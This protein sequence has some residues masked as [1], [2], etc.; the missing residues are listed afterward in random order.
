MMPS[1]YS[2]WKNLNALLVA[3]VGR[4]K[5]GLLSLLVEGQ[6]VLFQT[7]RDAPGIGIADPVEHAAS[8]EGTSSLGSPLPFASCSLKAFSTL[9]HSSTVVG[10]SKPRLSSHF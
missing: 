9:Y 2:L 3:L 8:G 7:V 5:D 1:E 6:Q 10:I 4:N